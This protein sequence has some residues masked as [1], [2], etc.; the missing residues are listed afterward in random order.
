[1]LGALEVLGI[2]AWGRFYFALGAPEVLGINAWAA[3][4]F[5]ARGGAFTLRLDG[6]FALF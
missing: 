6:A 4:L 2:D 3:L 5:C 1:M